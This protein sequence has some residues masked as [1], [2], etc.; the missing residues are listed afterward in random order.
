MVECELK[1]FLA[2]IVDIREADEVTGDFPRRVVAPVFAL[3]VDAGQFQRQRL[4]GLLRTQVP[5]EI[6]EFLIHA[7]GDSPHERLLVDAEYPREFRHVVDGRCKFFRICPDAVDG[8]ADREWLAMA[9]RDRAAM[10][11]DSLGAQ[12]TRVGLFVQ[13]VLVEDLQMHGAGS[14]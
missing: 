4:G 11:R 14:E 12:V 9:V 7:A 1:A 13:E 8:R 5:L 6:N 10:R 3:H 2:V